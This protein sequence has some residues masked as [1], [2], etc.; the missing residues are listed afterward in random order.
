MSQASFEV[1]REVGRGVH[2]TSAP[3][4]QAAGISSL[5]SIASPFRGSAGAD[6]LLTASI[7][8]TFFAS[9]R[10]HH[11]KSMSLWARAVIDLLSRNARTSPVSS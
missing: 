5:R 3:I 1:R 11:S 6:H 7:S 8:A 2:G 9:D 4:S 10:N